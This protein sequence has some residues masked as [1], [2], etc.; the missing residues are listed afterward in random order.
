MTRKNKDWWKEFFPVFRPIFNVIPARHT[1]AEARYIVKK[2]GLSRGKSFLDCPC[3]IGRI[4]IPLAKQGIKITGVD[5]TRSYLDELSK[6]AAGLN[7]KINLI[8][9]DMRRINFDSKFDAAGNLWTSF[10]YFDKESDNLLVLKRIY[11]ALKPGGKFILHIMNRDWIVRNFRANDWFESGRMKVLE[12]RRMD[13]ADS[14]IDSFWYYIK[15]GVEKVYRTRI[16]MYSYHELLEMM[17]KT[18]FTD[19]KG[20]GSMK[21]EPITWDRRMM[22]IIGSKPRG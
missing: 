21:D 9:S 10:G 3:G 22:F 18:G 4:S 7:L 2:L 1:N 15:G 11:R 13:L 5:I 6:K 8:E 17:R 12:Q 16:R 14:A 20:Y 19:I